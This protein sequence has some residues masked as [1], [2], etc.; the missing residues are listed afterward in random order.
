ML[1]FM[2]QKN[3]W[4]SSSS[5][6]LQLFVPV[7]HGLIIWVIGQT[8]LTGPSDSLFNVVIIDPTRAQPLQLFATKCF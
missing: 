1:D 3:H 2:A 5:K 6:K 8:C 7:L 4:H